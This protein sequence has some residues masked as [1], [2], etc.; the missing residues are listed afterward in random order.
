[1]IMLQNVLP[2]LLPMFIS[3]RTLMYNQ[4]PLFPCLSAC[5]TSVYLLG[6]VLLHAGDLAAPALNRLPLVGIMFWFGFL[7]KDTGQGFGC[8]WFI[9]KLISGE[10]VGQNTESCRDWKEVGRW[11]REGAETGKGV[12][13]H[14]VTTI[15][16]WSSSWEH[17]E[18]SR[19]AS[20]PLREICLCLST[21]SH[22]LTDWG[23]LILKHFPL[24][25]K[26][27]H[28]GLQWPEKAL[29]KL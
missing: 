7:L 21:K 19:H 28:S 3:G 27:W 9:C 25:S 29:K 18:Q 24:A 12:D 6:S 15:S 23:L 20:H 17:Q 22:E 8:K 4:K 14:V 10:G 5:L 26:H 11:D 1:M 16:N 13:F 2:S